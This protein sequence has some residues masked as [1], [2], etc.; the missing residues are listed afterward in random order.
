MELF[1][2]LDTPSVLIDLDV[3]E[4]N[5]ARMQAIADKAGVRLRPHTKTHKSVWVAGR[6]IAHGASG[7]TVAK[8][9]EAEVMLEGGIQDI[10]IAYP[11]YGEHKL[12]RLKALLERAK[13]TLSLDNVEVAEGISRLGSEMGRKIPVYL[14]VDT[15]IHRLGKEPGLETVRVARD[16]VRLPG[17]DLIGLFTHAGQGHDASNL[18]ELKAVA[19]YEGASLVET[20]ELMRREGIEVREISVG[21]S[22]TAPF[23]GE[24]PGVT[25]MRPGT[26]VYNDVMQV[27]VGVATETQCAATIL[28]T[29]VSRPAPDR[30][31]VDGGSKTFTSDIPSSYG[32]GEKGPKR[33]P[34]YGMVVGRPDLILQRLNEEHGMMVLT[35]P[36][37]GLKVGDRLRII[38]NHVCAMINLHDE[39]YGVRGGKVERVIPVSGRGKIR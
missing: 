14:E 25:E 24:V 29:V 8:T 16:L 13:I 33:H 31:V 34:G 18:E 26:Y 30:A 11:L 5:I 20:A 32:H 4:A 7:I 2:E 17:I 27:D 3:M 38:P 6:Q 23:V 28:V 22:P 37:R 19:R 21:S 39:V 35:D 15:G 1:P 9:G 36:S 10:L 12:R